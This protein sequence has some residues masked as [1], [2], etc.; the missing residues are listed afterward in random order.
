MVFFFSGEPQFQEDCN[1]DK[2]FP[3]GVKACGVKACGSYRGL[4]FSASA[5]PVMIGSCE[6]NATLMMARSRRLQQTDRY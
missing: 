5:P 2:S 3:Y 4:G 6:T 1:R